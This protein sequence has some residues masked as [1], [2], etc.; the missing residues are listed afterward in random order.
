MAAFRY[1]ALDAAGRELSGVLQ[2]DTARQARALLRA[3]GLL[4]SAVDVVSAHTTNR[5]WGRRLPA[6]ELSLLTQQLATLLESGLT[7]EQALGR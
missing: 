1:R 2:A 6:A 5:P 4:P 7:V 3:Q